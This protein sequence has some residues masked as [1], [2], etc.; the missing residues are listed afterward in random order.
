MP[1]SMTFRFL[2]VLSVLALGAATAIAQDLDIPSATYPRLADFAIDSDAFAPPGWAVE[3]KAT[4]DLDKDGDED[5]VFVLHETD[6]AKILKNEGL[7]IPELNSNPRILGV[8]F[9]E[10]AGYRLALQNN[11][12]IPRHI[13]PILED[14]FAADYGLEIA[15]GAFSVTLINFANAGSWEAGEAKLTFR[16]QNNRF[17]LI[18]WERSTVRRNTGETVGRSAN[19]STG[20]L[21]VTTGSIEH[22]RTKVAKKEIA[23]K[24]MPI[25]E[26]GDGLLF[27]QGI[28]G[29]PL[30]D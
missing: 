12:V 29:S 9:R 1:A 13:D 5:V 26:V 10:G 25:D 7:G 30:I 20:M 21:Q 14:P 3:A 4:G 27:G 2:A 19:F 8:G 11:T 23:M 16:W 6:P 22:D 15:R 18:G 28:D 17:E 24:P